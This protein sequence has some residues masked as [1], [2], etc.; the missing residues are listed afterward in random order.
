MKYRA[1]YIRAAKQIFPLFKLPY[2][3]DLA[4]LNNQ[5]QRVFLRRPGTERWH[6]N[7]TAYQAQQQALIPI[8]QQLG[9]IATVYPRQPKADITLIHGANVTTM[10]ERINFTN[11]LFATGFQTKQLIFLTGERRLDPVAENADVLLKGYHGPPRQ[12]LP[13][14]E[15]AAA[16]FLWAQAN[17]HP[18]LRT[19]PIYF[20]A[21]PMLRGEDG[22][23]RRPNTADTFSSCFKKLGQPNG[24]LRIVAVS[25]NPYIPYQQLTGLKTI[26]EVL[27]DAANLIQLETVGPA[28]TQPLSMAI[29][30]DLV[31]R[32][33]YTLLNAKRL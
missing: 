13:Q 4:Y 22:Q 9:M 3:N 1:Q 19:V 24:P 15:A 7:H 14:T 31:A 5:A 10:R 26:R 8:F 6:L 21:V 25:N 33:L 16:K 11:L 29:M 20:D 32:I 23:L 28:A 17:L 2:A 12:S 30:L 18:A 27:G